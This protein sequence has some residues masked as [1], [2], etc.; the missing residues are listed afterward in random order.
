MDENAKARDQEEQAVTTRQG[1]EL[2]HGRR[3]EDWPD[4]L[5][6]P[7]E[8]AHDEFELL[9]GKVPGHR[10]DGW[11]RLTGD[12][13]YSAACSAATNHTRSP[14]RGSSSQRAYLPQLR[15]SGHSVISRD[16]VD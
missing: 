9:K 15:P 12:E 10:W 1:W 14:D 4:L 5:T 7:C 6:E 11:R 8:L 13:G 3:R 16:V 2:S